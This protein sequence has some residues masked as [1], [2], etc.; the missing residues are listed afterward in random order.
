MTFAKL[1]CSCLFLLLLGTNALA[2]KATPYQL[3]YQQ[4]ADQQH[5]DQLWRPQFHYTPMQGEIADSTGLIYYKG[6]YHLFY[7]Y[8]KWERRRNNHKQW[9]YATSNDLLHWHEKPA[10]L[11]AQVDHK[12]GSGCGVVDWN[13]SSGLKKSDE[14]TLL[15]YYT[16]YKRGTC[17]TLSHDAG[18]TWNRY[19][20]NPI[21]GGFDDIRDPLIFWYEPDE[22]WRMVRY[23]KRGF[24]FY[25]SSNLLDWD[26]LSRIDGFYECPDML[27]LPVEND[28]DT[29]KW[30][31]FGGNHDYLLG[32]FDGNKFVPDFDE[33]IRIDYGGALYATQTWR[34]NRFGDRPI[35]LSAIRYPRNKE[36]YDTLMSMTWSGAQTFPC[37][38]T[39]KRYTD[40]IRLCRTPITEI[41]NLHRSHRVWRDLPIA[42]GEN[43]LS[44]MKPGICEVILEIDLG[45]ATKCEL[46]LGSVAIKYDAKEQTI[47]VGKR[48]APFT[49]P[50]G[51]LKLHVLVDRSIIEVF[52][53]GGRIT[54]TDNFFHGPD[55]PRKMALEVEGG[56]ASVNH[57]EVNF[58]K[59]I[60]K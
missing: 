32:E 51:R 30:V 28:P 22:S 6:I 23:E 39:L 5:Y 54:F 4:V 57:L 42:P 2:Q 37:D 35:Q 25:K 36:F 44:E 33:K 60:W 1:A 56:Q 29:Q 55:V 3:S 53:D 45:E 7:M 58:L 12:P 24:A 49:A 18:K 27:R 10:I 46:T 50:A 34:H 15:A 47:Y 40:G 17:I 41:K 13:N 16:D 19:A 21:L 52:V 38:L 59:S 31:I 20:E 43:P 14:D 11:D 9:G 26:F 48:K 8:D